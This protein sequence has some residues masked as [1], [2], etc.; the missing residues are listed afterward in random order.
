MAIMGIREVNQSLLSTLTSLN[1]SSSTSSSSFSVENVL[2]AAQQNYATNKANQE[3]ISDQLSAVSTLQ[4][5]ISKLRTA[6]NDLNVNGKVLNLFSDGSDN[7]TI[8]SGITDFV[9]AFNE[10]RSFAT[11]NK[12][13]FQEDFNRTVGNFLEKVESQL[14]DIGVSKSSDGSLSIDADTLSDALTNDFSAVKEAFGGLNG[15]ATRVNGFA[16]SVS[17]TGTYQLLSN[18]EVPQQRSRAVELMQDE[19]FRTS[20]LSLIR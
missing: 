15:L 12:D 1:R 18:I 13:F 11:S 14:S 3:R 19:L 10:L 20:I 9:E 5:Q 16:E 17:R 4:D 7:A 8:Q 2:L 6:A